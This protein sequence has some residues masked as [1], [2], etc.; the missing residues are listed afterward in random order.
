RRPCPPG[1]A[2]GGARRGD[3]DELDDLRAPGQ[4][5]PR[6]RPCDR[7]GRGR[8]RRRRGARSS[9]RARDEL[10]VLSPDLEEAMPLVTNVI[11]GSAPARV[12]L[13]RHGS[14]ADERA[15]GGLLPYLDPE[16]KFVTVLPR[17]PHAAPPGFSWFDIQNPDPA[18]ARQGQLDAL[19]Q[20]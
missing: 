4:R 6:R 12:L 19:E 1:R 2:V 5:P 17:A 16:G 18:V 10:P 14:G 3:H 20:L 9:R 13:M 15:L 11:E 8:A 7:V